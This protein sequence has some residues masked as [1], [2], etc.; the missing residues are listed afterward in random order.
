MKEINLDKES[1]YLLWTGGFDSTY[2]LLNLLIVEHRK[3]IPF[4]I[5]DTGRSSACIELQRMKE[6]KEA[7]LKEYPYT[8]E[9]LQDIQTFLI[10]E[11]APDSDIRE[12]Y[13]EIRK[14]DYLGGQ[15]EWLARFCKQ[16][17]I[18][19]AQLCVV[20]LD[21]PYFQKILI[22]KDNFMYVVDEKYK[23]NKEYTLFK[24]FTFPIFT[25][26]KNEMVKFT[27]ERGLENIIN[28]TWFCHNPTRKKEA[29]GRCG[30]CTHVIDEGLG[31]RIP[32]KNRII[33]SFT[34][35]IINFIDNLSKN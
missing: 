17:G 3:V 28:M 10:S 16:K 27:K 9:L 6:I 18:S 19:E 7:I 25:L 33:S 2:Q 34:K 26:T 21:N 30:P 13:L 11:I 12:A 24:Y 35:P 29:C 22:P 8:S 4:Y 1:I 5:I 23:G 15:Y 32:L 31:W 14:N 20:S